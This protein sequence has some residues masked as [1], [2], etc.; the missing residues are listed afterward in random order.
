[1]NAK[2]GIRRAFPGFVHPKKFRMLREKVS[3]EKFAHGVKLVFDIQAKMRA[4]TEESLA[5]FRS[6]EIH[7]D[8]RGDAMMKSDCCQSGSLGSR[9]P[10]SQGQIVGNQ[11]N[12]AR[13]KVRMRCRGFGANSSA[14]RP[15]RVRS[16][17]D[18]TCQARDKIPS[19][20]QFLCSNHI[21]PPTDGFAFRARHNAVYQIISW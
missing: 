21:G 13:L 3:R 1:M 11:D 16:R 10:V 7:D 5:A 20:N 15:K 6:D 9:R 2:I 8:F 4:L 18:A 19:R 14:R 12:A 17:R